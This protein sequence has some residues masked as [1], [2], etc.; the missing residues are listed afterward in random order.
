[1]REIYYNSVISSKTA[2]E[3]KLLT[4]Y[5]DKINIVNDCIY[6]IGYDKEQSKVITVD[7]PFIPE[8]FNSEYGV[9]IEE[10]ILSI[11]KR[12]ETIKGDPF[13]KEI[14]KLVNSKEDYIFPFHETES[15]TRM[16]TEEVYTIM[17]TLLNFSPDQPINKEFIWWYYAFKLNWSV[18]LLLEGHNCI[19][20]SNN[21]NYLFGELLRQMSSTNNTL[22]SKGYTKS[23]AV[24]AI[25][26]KLPNPSLLS[27]EDVL[28]LKLRLKDELQEFSQTIN[29]IEIKN[30]ILFGSDDMSDEHYS[31]IFY[32]EIQKPLK[33][34]EIKMAN[35][36]S[37]T[38]R[39]LI[40]SMKNPKSFAPLIG[41][42]V[43]SLPIEYTLMTSLGMI[44]GQSYLQYKE[45]QRNITNNG[46]YFLLKL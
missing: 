40:A 2:E 33:D 14:S 26:L 42:V 12:D 35:L 4:L 32:N 9:L 38:F 17:S 10:G 6:T 46:L 13:A 27:F 15:D 8:S 36:N 43:A 28:E 31:S 34:L 3:I 24:D 23:L 45:E 1:M 19:N 16:I 7:L 39:E 11:T 37:K 21:L 30:K 18:R 5:Y 29:S 22:G 44:A 41:T 25:K 20:G